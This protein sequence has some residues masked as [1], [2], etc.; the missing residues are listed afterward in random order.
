MPPP[1]PPPTPA[2]RPFRAGLPPIPAGP[3]PT[4]ATLAPTRVSLASTQVK[5]S[6]SLVSLPFHRAT[7]SPRLVSPLRSRGSLSLNPAGPPSTT[8]T[9]PLTSASPHRSPAI[10]WPSRA[11]LAPP[12]AKPPTS[13]A[14]PP[15][16]SVKLPDRPPQILGNPPRISGNRWE[17]PRSRR[18]RSETPPFIS[19]HRRSASAIRVRPSASGPP[20]FP[21]IRPGRNRR[22]TTLRLRRSTARFRPFVPRTSSGSAQGCRRLP[23]VLPPGRRGPRPAES[24]RSGAG[25]YR[26]SPVC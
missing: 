5:S 17:I 16:I 4:L 18:L 13:S 21:R 11:R 26:W 25:W 19:V 24:V 20:T 12:T 7:L 15:A 22:P 14:G 9:P 23:R 1:S 6:L 10:S 3:P 2:G 8:A